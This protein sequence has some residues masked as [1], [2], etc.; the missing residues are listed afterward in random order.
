MCSL[1][2][3]AFDDKRVAVVLLMFWLTL[4]LILFKDLGLLETGYMSF[5]PSDTTKFMGVVLDSWYKWSLVAL[6][7][8]LNTCVND[9]M[10]DAISPWILNTIS[11][12]KTKYL[13]YPPLVCLLI[14][15]LWAIYCNVMSVFGLMIALS[16]IDFVFI[17]TLADL[18]VN[19]YTNMKFMRGKEHNPAKYYDL[20]K[21]AEST[22]LRTFTIGGSED[23]GDSVG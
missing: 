16:Q 12:H 1:I 13:P 11:D 17:R 2:D 22:E 6:F 20:D 19:T 15:Q 10:S 4:V 23:G 8:F 5:G 3:K 7:T 21:Q 14:S 9:F 18:L